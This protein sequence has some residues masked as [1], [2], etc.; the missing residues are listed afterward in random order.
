MS[1]VERIHIN[2]NYYITLE[3]TERHNNNIY[4]VQVCPRIDENLCGYPIRKI[5]YS[6]NEKSKAN[7]TFNRY[8][9]K[10]I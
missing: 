2:N 5:T 9:K 1:V 3:I 4:V 8:V 7:N 10:Y 6:I